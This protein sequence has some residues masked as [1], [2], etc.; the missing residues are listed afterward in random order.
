MEPHYGTLN[1]G[2]SSPRETSSA[3]ELLDRNENS[4]IQKY[5]YSVFFI[6]SN[7]FC[8]RFSYYGMRA[9][10]VLYLTRWLSFEENTATS[11]YHAFSML[12]YFMPLIGAV[13]ADGYV[14]R[15][16]TILSLSCVYFVGSLVLSLTAMPPPGRVGASIG[17]VLIACGTGGIKASVAPFGADQFGPGQETWQNSFFSAFYFMINL[18]SMVSIILTPIL[19]ADVECFGQN[20]YVLAFGIPAALMFL[21]IVLFFIG[22]RMYVKVPPSGNVIGKTFKCIFYGAVGRLQRTKYE[23]ERS[24]WLYYADDKFENHFIEDVR[25]LLKVLLMFLPLPMF[26]ALSDQQGSRWTLQ[27]EHMN[28]DMG[29]FGT[30][31]PDQMQALNPLLILALIPLLDKVVYPLLNK[32]H[33]PSRPLQKMVVGLFISSFAFVA[34][35]FVQLKIDNAEESPMQADMSGLTMFNTLPCELQVFSPFFNDTID[36]KKTSDFME[37]AGGKYQIGIKSDC[38]KSGKKTANGTFTVIEGSAYRLFAFEDFG[39]TLRLALFPDQRQKAKNGNAALSIFPVTNGAIEKLALL[40][41]VTTATT[42]ANVGSLVNI[43]QFQPTDFMVFEP[44]IYSIFVPEL[45]TDKLLNMNVSLDLKSGGVYTAFVYGD[46][47]K[48]TIALYT[49]ISEN[50]VSILWLVPQ[51]FL[52]TM[53]EV[54]FSVAGLS[55][56]YSQAPQSMKSVVQALWL[57]TVGIGDMVVI[58]VANIHSIPSQMAEFFLFACLMFI[59]TL[60]FMLMSLFYEYKSNSV[61]TE[62]PDDTTLTGE[63]DKGDTKEILEADSSENLPLQPVKIILTAAE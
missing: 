35:G 40:S 28:G 21:S 62:L 44:N 55:F 59:D 22:R 5:P 49:G 18:G 32:C 45:V 23:E 24:H 50:K 7:E 41:D 58:I 63:G 52:I 47:T 15:Y 33:I 17:L 31:K 53:G 3:S 9:I 19:R 2:G 29:I 38:G 56:A 11:I 54:L 43:S 25:R 6:L 61:Y 37:T 10:L 57:S 60:I 39:G 51:Y 8:E 36:G 34:A 42:S 30:I 14:G 27:A 1:D 48:L 4:K 12:C 46:E 26:W 16:K 13:I 20:C